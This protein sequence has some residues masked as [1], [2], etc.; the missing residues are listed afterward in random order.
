MPDWLWRAR[1]A[2]GEKDDSVGGGIKGANPC[3]VD[4][5]RHQVGQ[6]C[7]DLFE[8]CHRELH[9]AADPTCRV[10]ER[11]R[12]QHNGR[13]GLTEQLASHTLGL[14][15]VEMDRYTAKRHRSER[16]RDVLHRIVRQNRTVVAVIKVTLAKPLHRC[17]H[18][19]GHLRERHT[20]FDARVLVPH[21]HKGGVGLALCTS[22][23]AARKRACQG[24]RRCR[25]LLITGARQGRASTAEVECAGARH[26][27]LRPIDRC[28]ACRSGPVI[29]E[30]DT[31]DDDSAR[32]VR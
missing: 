24:R 3:L 13:L 17:E 9:I 26:V 4:V 2:A 12:R 29:G 11:R 22:Q 7:A 25:G 21:F 14:A 15:P 1:G 30:L 19:T 8:R 31:V 18:A 32:I 20:Q 27:L 28:V 16:Q 5:R 6:F 23:K 10:Q